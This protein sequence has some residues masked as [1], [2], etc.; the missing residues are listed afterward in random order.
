MI[1][2]KPT[3]PVFSLTILA[4][5]LGG[6]SIF[7]SG[8]SAH[9]AQNKAAPLPPSAPL[10]SFHAEGEG[11]AIRRVVVLPLYYDEQTT[12]GAV[13]DMDLAFNAELGK[14]SLFELVP[15]SRAELQ[16]EFGKPQFSSVENLPADLLA[17]LRVEYGADGVLFTD[18]THYFPYHPITIGVRMKL[19][20]TVSGQIHWDFDHLF[21]SSQPVTSTAAQQ[22]FLKNNPAPVPLPEDGSPILQSPARFSRYVA[23]EAFRSLQNVSPE[24]ENA[25]NSQQNQ[26]NRKHHQE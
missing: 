22:F 9:N 14:T 10:P 17:R 16:A 24:Q 15:L 12:A 13:P 4:L 6:C 1:P 19:V 25:L 2:M 20:D 23:Y 5:L 3:H 21:D 11:I 26:P 8:H 7:N 18:I